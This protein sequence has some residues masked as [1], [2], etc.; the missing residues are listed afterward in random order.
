MWQF[1]LFSSHYLCCCSKKKKL[2]KHELVDIVCIARIL[3]IPSFH[4]SGEI[5]NFVINMHFLLK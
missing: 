3:F 5:R 1:K 2:L 4:Q